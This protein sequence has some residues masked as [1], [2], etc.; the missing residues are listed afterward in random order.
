MRPRTKLTRAEAG[1][2]G[3]LSNVLNHDHEHF[4]KLGKSGGRPRVLSYSEMQ[5][6]ETCFSNK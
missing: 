5:A 2:K 3:G 4:V 1:Q 6:R